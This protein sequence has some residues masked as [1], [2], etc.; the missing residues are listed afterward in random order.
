MDCYLGLDEETTVVNQMIK[1]DFQSLIDNNLENILDKFINDRRV[2]SF[3]EYYN[4]IVLDGIV[5]NFGKFS[6]YWALHMR[7]EDHLFFSNNFY[8]N[9]KLKDEIIKE[10]DIDLFYKKYCVKKESRTK[11]TIHECERN[12][13]IF[14]CKLFH[15]ILPN[16][17]PPMD[18]QIIK[19]FGLS[20]KNKID[21]YKI[22]KFGYELFL[23]KNEDIIDQIKQAFTR[24]EFNYIRIAELSNYRIIDMIYWVNLNR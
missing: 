24:K 12:E 2:I 22:I 5:I 9:L 16:D 10:N 1:K 3:I 23:D 17:F 15:V 11:A 4:T 18:N 19:H 14:C 20:N 21:S 13:A 7:R 8:T 6:H